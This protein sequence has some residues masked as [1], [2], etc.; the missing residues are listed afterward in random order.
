LEATADVLDG[1]STRITAGEAARLR[2]REE[3][4]REQV[5]RLDR[6]LEAYRAAVLT[7]GGNLLPESP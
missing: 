1:I 2:E 3:G 4:L 5:A 6:Q 7:L